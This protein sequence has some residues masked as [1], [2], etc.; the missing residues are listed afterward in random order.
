[1]NAIE[2]TQHALRFGRLD[3]T[4]HV[5]DRMRERSATRADVESAIRRS[6]PQA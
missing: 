4:I 3:Y 2:T 1:M 6:L 5:R